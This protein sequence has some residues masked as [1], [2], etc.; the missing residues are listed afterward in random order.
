MSIINNIGLV[1]ADLDLNLDLDKRVYRRRYE[2]RRSSNL[3]LYLK[4]TK[5]G[6]KRFSIWRTEFL[7]PAMWH[8][9]DINFAT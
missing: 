4:K 9:H 7:H 5:N 3:K 2:S 8:D 1:N 6:E